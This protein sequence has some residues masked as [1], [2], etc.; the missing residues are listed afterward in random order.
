MKMFPFH[1]ISQ[2]VHFLLFS[3]LSYRLGA[4]STAAA[5]GPCLLSEQRQQQQQ[6]QLYAKTKRRDEMKVVDP[7]IYPFVRRRRSLVLFGVASLLPS[8]SPNVRMFAGQVRVYVAGLI[9]ITSGSKGY[10]QRQRANSAPLG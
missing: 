2:S 8:P 6:Q 9:L 1:E 4:A 10:T 5:A 7:F 3:L